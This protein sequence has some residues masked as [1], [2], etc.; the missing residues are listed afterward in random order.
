MWS[1]HI[2]RP[3][4]PVM[5]VIYGVFCL[6]MLSFILFEVLD[7]DGS[8]FP[9]DPG[10]M[11]A[12]VSTAEAEHDIRRAL[13]MLQGSPRMELPPALAL[14]P[15]E[16]MRRLRQALRQSRP[17]GLAR[18]GAFSILLPRAALPDPSHRS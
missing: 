4:S 14:A 5:R 17:Y 7:I 13:I 16:G 6:C 3:V 1:C 11:V 12:R 9:R 15:N 2:H 18:P 8:D 10:A